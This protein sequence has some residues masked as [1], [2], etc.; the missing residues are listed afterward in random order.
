MA[1]VPVATTAREPP[2][3]LG[4]L[5]RGGISRDTGAGGNTIAGTRAGNGREGAGGSTLAC[6]CG[7][8]AVF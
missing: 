3:V 7:S 4:E 5:L 2:G 1:I 8:G 6:R